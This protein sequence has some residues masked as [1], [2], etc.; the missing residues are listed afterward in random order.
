[1]RCTK[2]FASLLQLLYGIQLLYGTQLRLTFRCDNYSIHCGLLNVAIS[3]F[4]M[5]NSNI[6][7]QKL[8]KISDC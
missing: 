8:I 5:N 7:H 2:F 3:I 6:I 4:F 1:M